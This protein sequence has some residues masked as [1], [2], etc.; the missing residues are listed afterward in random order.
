M[1]NGYPSPPGGNYRPETE[2]FASSNMFPDGKEDLSASSDDE[3]PLPPISPTADAIHL[4]AE[5]EQMLLKTVK[6][7]R[8]QKAELRALKRAYRKK[9][10]EFVAQMDR[11]M[12]DVEH[13]ENAL[14]ARI[15]TLDVEANDLRDIQDR[16]V[17]DKDILQQRLEE[18][19]AQCSDSEK[20]VQFLM[21][22]L[23][24]LLSA[25]GSTERLQRELLGAM[26]TR[27]WDMAQKLEGVRLK[28]S[29]ERGNNRDMAVHL[30]DE[31]RRTK[32]LHDHLCAVQSNF[33]HRQVCEG[34]RLQ[35]SG[36]VAVSALSPASPRASPAVVPL[37]ESRVG[38]LEPLERIP[39][40][41]AMKPSLPGVC[42]EPVV[43]AANGP[44]S[45]AET[46]DQGSFKGPP[47]RG[48]DPVMQ[49][50]RIFASDDGEA[51]G[52]SRKDACGEASAAS[53]GGEIVLKHSV[54]APVS[55]DHVMGQK[56][57][58]VS[59]LVKAPTTSRDNSSATSAGA[60]QGGA[61]ASPRGSQPWAPGT[62]PHQ[63]IDQ[64][65]AGANGLSGLQAQSSSHEGN[66]AP[67]ARSRPASTASEN[68][69]MLE[70]KL[71]Q[72]LDSAVFESPVVRVSLGVYQFGLNVRALVQLR[73]DGEAEASCDGSH[74]QPLDEFIESVSKRGRQ[75]SNPTPPQTAR[76]QAPLAPPQTPSVTT[77]PVAPETAASVALKS[78]S[79]L[80]GLAVPLGHSRSSPSAARPGEERG[81]VGRGA[82]AGALRSPSPPGEVNSSFIRTSGRTMS[83]PTAPMWRDPLQTNSAT[84]STAGRVS[85]ANQAGSQTLVRAPNGAHYTVPHAHSGSP[86][87]VSSSGHVGVSGPPVSNPWLLLAAAGGDPAAASGMMPGVNA[88]PSSTSPVRIQQGWRTM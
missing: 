28:L 30:S 7:L 51:Q 58:V 42:S 46:A 1:E 10:A 25:A 19:T 50:E 20:R 13:T 85:P 73:E 43:H 62:S 41:E 68:V 80:S 57:A 29:E 88:R 8:R 6:R 82:G 61:H 78:Q 54:T 66:A 38:L 3:R 67:P 12:D 23:V 84:S 15:E 9:E 21:D 49:L 81:Q 53:G 18:T 14:H 35:P 22:R 76:P 17:K 37:A 47:N 26:E 32:D 59:Q 83:A 27:E 11:H 5:R 44:V 39:G 55:V 33:F 24:A 2:S 40:T 45:H 86:L 52:L 77:A 56:D 71:R 34:G 60:G 65:N 64:R 79:E 63:S 69:A 4:L 16:Q 74:F 70:A 48:E 31:Q 72:A 75:M 87:N 36:S